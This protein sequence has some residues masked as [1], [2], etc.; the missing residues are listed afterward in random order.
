MKAFFQNYS[1]TFKNIVANQS[2]LTTLILSVF[3]YS[4]F[5]PTAYQAEHAEFLPIVIVDEEQSDL[6]QRIITEV[7]KSPNIEVKQITHN[8]LD[9][10]HLVQQQQA[11]GILLLPHNLSQS[12]ARGEVGGVG[13]YLSAAYFLR[14]KQIGVG[15]ASSIENAIQQQLEKFS[16]RTQFAAH[17]PVHQVPLF[18]V[19]SGYGSYIFPAVAP[20]IIHQTIVLGLAM[21]IAG[22]R[23]QNWQA[24]PAKFF[25]V[26]AALLSIGCLGCCYLFGFTFWLYDYPRGGNFWGMLLAVPVFIS[27]VIGLGLL[28]ASFLDISERAGHLIVFT[29]IPLFL[30][31]GVAWPHL[32]MPEW[33]QALAAPLPSTQGVQ[34]FIQLN[35]MG[36]PTAL[37]FDKILYLAG[38]AVILL[39]W[40]YWRL[41]QPRKIP[42]TQHKQL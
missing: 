12:V 37:V 22:Y 18:N 4:F 23:E 28:I 14:T 38:L 40:S 27:C 9:A 19:L 42:A 26:F 39:A 36:V 21:L 10:Q 32:A 33:L 11:D 2:I 6:S 15:I 30:L 34:L 25:G 3:F 20:L 35:Q 31:T 29:S 8:F 17:I 13:L 5:Y 16:H 1:Q 24:T 7:L 41:S